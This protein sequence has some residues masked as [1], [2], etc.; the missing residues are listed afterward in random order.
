M[1][2]HQLE[3]PPGVEHLPLGGPVGVHPQPVRGPDR[4]GVGLQ[5]L[6][7]ALIHGQPGE[8]VAQLR[9]LPAQGP[10]RLQVPGVEGHLRPRVQ[11]QVRLVADLHPGR[12]AGV[13][14][15]P[16]ARGVEGHEVRR[17]RQ[18][19]PGAVQAHGEV[20]PRGIP[21][22]AGVVRRAVVAH[23]LH[24]PERPLRHA[25]EVGL[26]PGPV[27]RMH[28]RGERRHPLPRPPE[29]GPTPPGGGGSTSR[30][31][32]G[33][34]SEARGR[35][36][37]ASRGKGTA[38][39]GGNAIL[40]PPHSHRPPPRPAR[41]ARSARGRAPPAAVWTAEPRGGLRFA[42]REEHE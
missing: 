28:P 15:G 34:S 1:V 29:R 4:L 3:G 2:L 31:N 38:C 6:Q 39:G 14:Q 20:Q 35:R 23:H 11:L 36:I 24:P 10:Q 30:S 21:E 7:L 40:Y 9:G 41:P 13:H 37:R 5:P 32:S 22:Q 12:E 16:Q 18:L 42:Q 25:P 26:L 19:V 8:A 33:G 17:G 27:R